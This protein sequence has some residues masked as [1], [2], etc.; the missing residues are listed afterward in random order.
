[1]PEDEATQ[2][3]LNESQA[4]VDEAGDQVEEESDTD[5]L[6]EAITVEADSAGTLRTKLTV[7]VPRAV[8]DERA[9]KQI[10][11]LRREA[12]VPGFRPGR[13]PRALVE[14]RFGSEMQGDLKDKLI[15]EAYLAAVDKQGLEVLG[16]P[17][18][19][20]EKIEL[21]E[22]GDLS[23][24]CE[25][26]LKP[27]FELPKLDGIA[28]E[29]PVV[30][31]TDEDVTQRIDQFR[32]MR[33]QLETVDEA[34]KDDDVVAADVAVKVGDEV[35]FEQ[36]DD[37]VPVRP[38]VI[39]G[40]PLEQLGR[41]LA[42]VKAGEARQITVELPEQYR[43]EEQ[44]GKAATIE[45][46]VKDVRRL[47]LPELDEAF[48]KSAGAESIDDLREFVRA[49][50]EARQDQTSRRAMRD[51]L[52][53]YLRDNTELDVPPNLSQRQTERMVQRQMQDLL[54]RG[55]PNEEVDKRLDELRTTAV[56]QVAADLK[57]FFIMDRVSEKLEVEVR[58]EEI[59]AR[60]AEIARAYN[61][62]FD[63]VRDDLARRGGLTSLYVDLREQ[64]C[65]DR[66]LEQSDITDA[67]PDAAP[68]ADA[69]KSGK[70]KTKAKA[71]RK[72]PKKKAEDA[73]AD[74]T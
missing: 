36:A 2:E 18:L 73:S 8:I 3:E 66:L 31:V 44:R 41:E 13:A 61:Q 43:V 71:K 50:L 56:E 49:D 32:A 20:L 46:A 59:N 48:L 69:D 7:T 67:A 51:Q 10:D 11:E 16:D 65:V 29:R 40:I 55:V 9:D 47:A 30:E 38:S 35:V 54:S 74:E 17:D 12:Q 42:G 1:M 25:V 72:S 19:D 60:I 63:R 57:L 14:K 24:T 52:F 33:G 28:I 34:A 5:K 68:A 27:Q 23:F 6:K 15:A 4:N 53:A 58:E 62:R 21:P 22:Q 26:E 39:D 45:I 37:R 70:T 64:K